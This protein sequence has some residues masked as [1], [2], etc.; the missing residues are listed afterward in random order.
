MLIGI[1]TPLT[2]NPCRKQMCVTVRVA[3]PLFVSVIVWVHCCPQTRSRSYARADREL[4][5]SRGPEP[6]KAIVRGEPGAVLTIEMLPVAAP[7]VVGANFAVKI[8][9]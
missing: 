9:L 1:V 4:R 2:L 3:L 7:A 8:V 6:V 5:L